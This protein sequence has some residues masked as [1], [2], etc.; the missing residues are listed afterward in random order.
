MGALRDR[1]A[2]DSVL[3][4]LWGGRRRV[5][6][7]ACFQHGAIFS[8]KDVLALQIFC[9]VNMLG[10]SAL[11]L[12]AGAFLTSDLGNILVFLSLDLVLRLSLI[13]SWLRLSMAKGGARK[14][15]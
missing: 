13:L 4:F 8:R 7:L 12:F 5:L 6:I 1:R 10:F 11:A 14:G 15:E 9:R 2:V 3:R